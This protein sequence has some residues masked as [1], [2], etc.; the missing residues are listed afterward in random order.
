V[1]DGPSCF[2]GNRTT[3]TSVE[4]TTELDTYSE[5]RCAMCGATRLLDGSFEPAVA[6]DVPI[7]LW[8]V[9][10]GDE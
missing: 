7:S 5:T 2:C 3:V 10:G 4:V 9:G 8:P 6:L 1:T